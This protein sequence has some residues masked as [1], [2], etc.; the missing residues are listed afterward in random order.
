MAMIASVKAFY[1]FWKWEWLKML[2]IVLDGT[3]EE[4][5]AMLEAHYND[6]FEYYMHESGIKFRLGFS[7]SVLRR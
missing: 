3:D 5:N 7:E 6:N 4:I 1:V 2:K